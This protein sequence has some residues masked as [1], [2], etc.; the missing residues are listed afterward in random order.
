LNSDRGAVLE[1]VVTRTKLLEEVR[2]VAVSATVP[3][4]DDVAKWIG[5]TSSQ[6]GFLLH[7]ALLITLA[8]QL[9]WSLERSTG[10]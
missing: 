3:N 6:A 2:V 8:Q 1:V 7:L 4:V 5:E 10:R 9:F